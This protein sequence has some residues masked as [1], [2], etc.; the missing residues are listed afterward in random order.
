[1]D[2][3]DEEEKQNFNL[4]FNKGIDKIRPFTKPI[5]LEVSRKPTGKLVPTVE[6]MT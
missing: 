6:L 5:D 3:L 1:M 2:N 4:Y